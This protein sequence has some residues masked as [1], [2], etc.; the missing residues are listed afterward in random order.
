MG[1]EH[2]EIIQ[3]PIST[4]KLHGVNPLVYLIDVL[5][6]V[7]VH[8]ANRI[9]ELTP[10]QWEEM[11]ADILCDMSCNRKY[12]MWCYDAG[13]V[14]EAARQEME[15]YGYIPHVKG[16]GSEARELKYDPSKKARWRVVEVAHSW[17][18]RFRKLLVR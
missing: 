10:R 2:A 17:F 9:N 18:N 13:Y 7:E 8:T 5:Q 15:S 12:S 1:S 11:F 4:R 6:C 3:S 16:R 14:G